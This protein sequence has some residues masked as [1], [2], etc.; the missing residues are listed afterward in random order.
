[1]N[2]EQRQ[3]IE[4]RLIS[5]LVRTMAAHGWTVWSVYDGGE[6]VRCKDETEILDT[7]FSVDE[8]TI[9]FER[10][11]R[12]H[13][14][15]I[16][17]GNDGWDAIADYGYSEDDDFEQIMEAEVDPFVDQLEQEVSH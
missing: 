12:K 2:V 7:V 10:D 11:R 14:V 8:S 16:V 3:E 17:L 4:R 9:W 1:M 13:G 5:R 15:L 6:H